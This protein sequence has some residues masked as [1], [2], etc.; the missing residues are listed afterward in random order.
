MINLLATTVRS[1]RASNSDNSRKITDL[2]T[3][4]RVR[5]FAQANGQAERTVQTVKGLIK[6]AE[7]PYK[8]LLAY[9]NTNIEEVGL[10]PA[11]MFMGRR[12]KTDIPA[13]SPMLAPQTSPEIKMR[14]EVRQAKQKLQFEK[15]SGDELKP[16]NEGDTVVM[17]KAGNRSPWI[18]AAVT[19]KHDSPRSYVVQTPNN[20]NYRRNRSHLRKTSADFSTRVETDNEQ[21]EPPIEP[22]CE[23]Q[24]TI[25]PTTA[26]SG[27]EIVATGTTAVK[28][29][30]GRM[31]KTPTKFQDYV[32]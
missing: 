16:L 9:R 31:V 3:L 5:I 4:L 14:L 26:T 1:S 6:K 11:Q 7:D 19:G 8:A 10:S 17:R 32:K 28:T 2:Y 22:F 25:I 15:R 18:P 29:R 20:R 23:N 13:T 30:S 21:I 12:L 27:P 24:P